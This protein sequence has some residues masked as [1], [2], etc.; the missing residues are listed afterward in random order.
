MKHWLWYVL[1]IAA[2]AVFGFAPFQGT[3]VA[4]LNPVEL[5]RISENG[6]VIRVETDGGDVGE[7]ADLAAAFANLERRASQ[8]IFLETADYLLLEPDQ[9]HLLRELNGYLR[10]ACAV[11]LEFGQAE[12]EKVSEFLGTHKPSVTLQ[13]VRAG[14]HHLPALMVWEG[15]MQLV[16]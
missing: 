1:A 12:L 4:D 9:T 15:R 13:D 14:A 8:D 5:L 7:G 3:D 2:L 11:C 6:G 16:S 10:P